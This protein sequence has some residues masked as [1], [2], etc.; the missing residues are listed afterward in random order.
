M[1][2][3]NMAAG[4]QTVLLNQEEF[5]ASIVQKHLQKIIEIEFDKFIGADTYERTDNRQGYRNGSY[6]RLFNT[7]VGTIMLH[8]C[9]DRAGEFRT[10]LFAKYQRSEKAFV[11]E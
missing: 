6:K 11:L 2:V 10:E 8:V 5:L 7:R 4:S 9:R 1:D 3:T